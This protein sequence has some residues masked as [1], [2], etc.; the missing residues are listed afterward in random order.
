LE[1]TPAKQSRQTVLPGD[2]IT[3]DTTVTNHGA[4]RPLQPDRRCPGQHQLHRSGNRRLGPL[5]AR[6]YWRR[7]SVA[8]RSPRCRATITH[9]D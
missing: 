1:R 3:Y 5:R 2:K 6:S 9:T 4:R 8:L 7:L